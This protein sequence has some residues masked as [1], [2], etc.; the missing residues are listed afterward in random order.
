[1]QLCLL[2][3]ALFQMHRQPEPT[4]L[5]PLYHSSFSSKSPRLAVV[6]SARFPF[7]AHSWMLSAAVP[8]SRFFLVRTAGSQSENLTRTEAPLDRNATRTFVSG[9]DYIRTVYIFSFPFFDVKLLG[10]RHYNGACFFLHARLVISKPMEECNL[11][12]RHVVYFIR[13]FFWPC[14]VHP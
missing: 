14:L 9:V 12:L 8:V 11:G 7:L 1:V 10:I 13:N 2:R 4:E 3:Y 5:P 6:Q